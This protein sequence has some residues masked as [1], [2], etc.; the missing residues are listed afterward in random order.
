MFA[1][2]GFFQAASTTDGRGPREGQFS[3]KDSTENLGGMYHAHIVL[4][5]CRA[6]Q[7]HRESLWHC[8]GTYVVAFFLARGVRSREIMELASRT[9]WARSRC[10]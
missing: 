1:V 3:M 2:S 10:Y 9:F 7:E 5:V 4:S 6:S 8:W